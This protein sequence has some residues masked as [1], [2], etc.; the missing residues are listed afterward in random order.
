[1]AEARIPPWREFAGMGTLLVLL[2]LLPGW[3]PSGPWG[4]ASFTRGIFGLIGGALLYLAWYRRTFEISGV[5][6]ALSM[7][8]NPEESTHILAALGIALVFASRV[9]GHQFDFVPA[10][11][12]LIMSLIGLLMILLSIYAH[13]VFKGPWK[14]SE[15]E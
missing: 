2:T 3:A 15:E 9:I 13:M 11:F 10:P 8:K 1:M 4:Q 12:A 6:P 14:E 5:V 7:W